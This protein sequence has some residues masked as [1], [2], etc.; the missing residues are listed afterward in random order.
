MSH[1]TRNQPAGTPTW[2]DLDVP[3][4]GRAKEFYGALFGWEFEPGENVYTLCRLRGRAVAGF[5]HVPAPDSPAAALPGL[6]CVY[7]ATD[8]SEATAKRIADAG[9]TLTRRPVEIAD[10]GLLSLATDPSGSRFGL[11]EGRAL[12]GCETVNEPGSLLRNDLTSPDPGPAREF[13][14]AV[15]DFTLDGND[16]LPGAD[17]TFL[18][19]PDGHEIGGIM[20]DPEAPSAGWQTLFEVADTDV[21]VERAVAAGGTAETP[22]DTIYARMAKITDPFGNTFQ[23]GARLVNTP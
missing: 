11:W 4:V 10:Q 15:F 12:V 17:F 18:R 7:F 21:A 13:Y 2:T 14:P 1:V 20:G 5:R 3:D 19:R 16:D 8:D 23:V 6:W 22:S 9:G